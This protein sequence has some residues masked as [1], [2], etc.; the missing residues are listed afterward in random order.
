[1]NQ[2]IRIISKYIL[3]FLIGGLLYGCVEVLFRGRTHISM[4]I[5]GGIDFILIGLLNEIISWDVAMTSQ[6]ILSSL[7]I[8]LS[9]LISGIYLNIYL[10]LNVWD[11]SDLPYNFLGQ[12]SLEFSVIWFFFS[13]LPITLDDYL[14]Y[15]YLGEE[16]PHYKIL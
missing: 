14:R 4:L 11:Y 13:L 9:E 7:I 10:G 16:K 8:D 2:K 3:L 12:V 1:M 6:M 15:K 5:V